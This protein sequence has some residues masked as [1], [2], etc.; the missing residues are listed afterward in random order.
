MRITPKGIIGLGFLLRAVNSFYNGFIGRS[1][2]ADADSISFHFRAA[3]P[4]YGS[5]KYESF[6]RKDGIMLDGPHIYI[7]LLENIYDLTFSHMFVGSLV[8]SIIWYFSALLLLKSVRIAKIEPGAQ[9]QIFLFYS[10]LPSTILYTSIPL[11]EP[12]QLILINLILYS[13]ININYKRSGKKIYWVLA[14]SAIYM[15]GAMH[16]ALLYSGII[17]FFLL[18]LFILRNTVKSKLFWI[19]LLFIL[20]FSSFSIISFLFQNIYDLELSEQV[21]KYNLGLLNV[22][23]VRAVYRTSI[24][25]NNFG[26]FLLFVPTAFF[27]YLIEPLPYRISNIMDISLFTENLIRLYLLYN[28]IILVKKNKEDHFGLFILLYYLGFCSYQLG[29]YTQ[30]V[31]FYKKSLILSPNNPNA[32]YSL[33]QSYIDLN[34][35][36]EA[37]RQLKV[38]MGIDMSLFELLKLSFDTKF[39]S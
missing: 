34:N 6:F 16:Y 14:I 30:S 28:A 15:A 4:W 21:V 35:K 38:L 32:I 22:Q 2:G 18:M 3:N 29:D 1:L 27:Q 20:S 26:S 9:N 19:L 7:T 36:K 25:V 8:S 39:N 33:G 10:F 13:F 37:K 11:R 24:D 23:E 12:L 5:E 31:R 17:G